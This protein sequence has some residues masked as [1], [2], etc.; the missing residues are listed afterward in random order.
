MT[1]I[2]RLQDIPERIRQSNKMYRIAI[3]MAE[4]ANT[5]EAVLKGVQEGFVYPFFIGNTDIIKGN[6][7]D[8]ILSVLE[9]KQFI[10]CFD[11]VQAS[12]TGVKL[13]KEGK[14]DILM[15]GLIST[16]IFLKAVLNKETG[17][18]QQNGILSYVGTLEIPAYS[19][20]LLIS[21]PAVLPFPNLNQ[22][23]A[24][25]QY[26][27]EVAHYLGIKEPKVALIGTSEKASDKFPN[28]I[29][30]QKIKEESEQGVY[31]E[32]IID[33]PLDLFLA[34]DPESV[35]I[36]G[37]K[38]STEGMADVLIFPTLEASNPFYKGLMLFA[39]GEIAGLIRGTT[40]PVIVMSRS[41]S[42]KS[43]YYCLALACLLAKANI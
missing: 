2:R 43:K 31:G 10:S 27:V 8:K 16:D 21:D 34:C 36:K 30:F 6:I 12:E 23:R 41:E 33:G 26:A 42:F 37:I 19:K 38:T 24:M 7:P 1:L 18:L 9:D 3:V 28:S 15:K 39:K 11:N 35:K 22:K 32:C 40:H 4:D 20:L 25:V 29:D 13:V 17:I 14:A 5:I